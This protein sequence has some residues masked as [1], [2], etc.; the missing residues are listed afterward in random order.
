MKTVSAM[1]LLLHPR[2]WEALSSSSQQ[3]QALVAPRRHLPSVPLVQLQAVM[4][5][6]VATVV[7]AAVAMVTL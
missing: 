4:V 1:P 2:C 7:A 5:V 3:L 6:E